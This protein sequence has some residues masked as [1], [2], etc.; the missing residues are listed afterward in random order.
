MI[1]GCAGLAI[2]KGRS[3]P[4]LTTGTMRRADYGLLWVLMVLAL[5]GLATLVLR[6]SFAFGSVLVVHLA[7]VIVA[8]AIFLD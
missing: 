7:A 2:I 6:H 3:D 8:F 1:S 5:T 4:D